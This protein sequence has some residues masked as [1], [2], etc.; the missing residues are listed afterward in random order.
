MLGLREQVG[1]DEAGS[2]CASAITITSEGPAGRSIAGPPSSIA[3]WRFASLTQALPGPNSLSQAGTLSVPSAIAAIACAPPILNTLS[4]PQRHAACSTA[5]SALP[6]RR[7]GV[8][9]TTSGQPASRAGTPSMSAVD[10]SGALP[11]GTYRPTR[12]IGRR[13]RSQRTPGAVSTAYGT[14]IP[15]RW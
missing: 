5:G 6:S 8:H 1:G 4:M 13:I 14:A 15:A 3:S 2:A 10:G 11:A 9:S 7:G 12:A